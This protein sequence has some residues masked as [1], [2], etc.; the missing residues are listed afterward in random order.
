MISVVGQ[1]EE[2]ALQALWKLS[3]SA[4]VV[5]VYSSSVPAGIVISQNYNPG[6]DIP[7]GT[8]VMLLVSLGPEPS[9]TQP[10][11]P[12][13]VPTEPPTEPPTVPDF[14]IPTESADSDIVEPVIP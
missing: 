7:A 14:A 6:M 10:T 4:E 3:L 13:T 11:E 9:P 2:A 8:T 12:P 1:S 5:Y